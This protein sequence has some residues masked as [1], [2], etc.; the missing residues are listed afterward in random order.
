[1]ATCTKVEVPTPKPPIKVVLSMDEDEA[2]ALRAF[3]V[4]RSGFASNRPIDNIVKAL[5]KAGFDIDGAAEQYS[6][7]NNGNSITLE[8]K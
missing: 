5:D 8:A 2:W 4:I 3:L 7:H 1:M 6:A